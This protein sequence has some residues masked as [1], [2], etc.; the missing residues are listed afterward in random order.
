MCKSTDTGKYR[1]HEGARFI[2]GIQ[3]QIV[4]GKICCSKILGQYF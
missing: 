1:P 2:T 3:D 4:A